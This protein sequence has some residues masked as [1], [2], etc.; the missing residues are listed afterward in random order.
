MVYFVMIMFVVNFCG[1][2]HLYM[3]LGETSPRGRQC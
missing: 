1:V 2:V 3:Y